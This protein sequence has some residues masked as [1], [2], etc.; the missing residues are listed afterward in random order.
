MAMVNKPQPKAE[1]LIGSLLFKLLVII[2]LLLLLTGAFR[3]MGGSKSAGPRCDCV[4]VQAD[5]PEL[6]LPNQAGCW[7]ISLEPN[8]FSGKVFLPP[9]M[10]F[11]LDW[12]SAEPAQIKD[13]FGNIIDID[14]RTDLDLGISARNSIMQFKGRGSVRIYIEPRP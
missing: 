12:S 9:L 8:R 13:R 6:K 10:N 3:T 5:F 4:K 7:E 2:G 14:H 11:A 1:S